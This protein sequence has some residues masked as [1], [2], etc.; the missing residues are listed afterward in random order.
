M[1]VE[2]A[3]TYRF[4]AAHRLPAVPSGHQCARLHGH[5]F[6]V[7]VQVAGEVDESTGW[8]IDFDE[9]DRT[10]G[11]LLGELDHRCL[12]EIDGLC[13]PTS[14]M[15][16]RWLWQRLLPRLPLLSQVVVFESSDARCIYRGE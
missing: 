16:A 11:P 8:L 13:N 7:E 9:M 6:E 4:Q 5:S 1:R 14:E 12:N 3:R 10:V 15:L 2:L